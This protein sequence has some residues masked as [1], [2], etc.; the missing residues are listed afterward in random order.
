[1]SAGAGSLGIAR[2]TGSGAGGAASAASV[3]PLSSARASPVP[4][5][6]GHQP[7]PPTSGPRAPEAAS[8]PSCPSAQVVLNGT[9]SDTLLAAG[10]TGSW[11]AS[12]P[13]GQ[14]GMWLTGFQV[15]ASAAFDNGALTAGS[16]S[17]SVELELTAAP[18]AS[19]GGPGTSL[20]TPPAGEVVAS[21]PL[22][23][24]GGSDGS[25][26]SGAPS[27]LSVAVPAADPYLTIFLTASTP[28]LPDLVVSSAMAVD[29]VA[30]GAATN[31]VTGEGVQPGGES[32][33]S[34]GAP[35]PA[36][37]SSSDPSALTG[38]TVTGFEV[39]LASA[40]NGSA[41]APA[42]AYATATAYLLLT[43]TAGAPWNGP[44]AASASFPAGSLVL[45]VYQVAVP[46]TLGSGS[47]ALSVDCLDVV[48]PSATPYL[49]LYLVANTSTAA[50]LE[51]DLQ[52]TTYLT[53]SGI[54]GSGC[55]AGG[56][57]QAGGESDTVG[58]GSGGTGWWAAS[59][60]TDLSGDYLNG[61]QVGVTENF[62]GAP[63][64]APRFGNTL[65]WLFLSPV[66][67]TPWGS[68]GQ[69]LPSFPV[70][71]VVVGAWVL[72]V[73]SQGD[74]AEAGV[75]VSCLNVLVP[76]GSPYLSLLIH[77]RGAAG[78]TV[79]TQ[80]V[81]Y[82]T[83]TTHSTGCDVQRNATA[84]VSQSVA[85][86]VGAIP[87]WYAA[88]APGTFGGD[89]VAGASLGL[90]IAAD[91]GALSLPENS[92]ATA[93]LLATSSFFAGNNASGTAVAAL[94]P[95]TVLAAIPL[96]SGAG[97]GASETS[98]SLS[99]LDAVLSP[100]D[101]FLTVVL[102]VSTGPTAG[103]SVGVVSQVW[104]ESPSLTTSCPAP[105]TFS[106][107]SVQAGG[108]EDALPSAGTGW[109]VSSDP[110]SL[111]G[112][113][114]T[115]VQ[116]SGA[117]TFGTATSTPAFGEATFSLFFSPGPFTPWSSNGQALGAYPHEVSPFGSWT[118]RV[119]SANSSAGLSEAFSC[120]VVPV[121]AAAPYLSLL[122]ELSA[123][124]SSGL[125]GGWQVAVGSA[126]PQSLGS[127]VRAFP[128]QGDASVTSFFLTAAPT[129]GFPPYSAVW[130]L[131]NGATLP[132]RSINY[133]YTLPGIYTVQE[134]T[135]DSLGNSSLR[136]LTL[137]VS[138]V[139]AG[140]ATVTPTGPRDVGQTLSFSSEVQGG[141]PPIA[142]LWK[143]GDGSG[144]IFQNTTH[145]YRT[146]GNYS[147]SYFAND[148]AGQS[149]VSVLPVEI[150]PDPTASPTVL[151]AVAE[152]G[153]PV[154][155]TANGS[156]GVPPLSWSWRFGDGG[157]SNVADPV[158]TYASPG[159]FVAT[160][161]LN[162]SAGLSTNR[163]VLVTVDAPL[164][165]VLAFSS[166]LT[167]ASSAQGVLV[168]SSPSGGSG[169]YR[170]SWTLNGT[171]LTTTTPSFRFSPVGAGNFSFVSV[172]TD[173]AG[174]SA[175]DQ[176]TLTLRPP[177][178]VGL[179][180][181]PSSVVLGG[182]FRVTASV[183]APDGPVALVWSYLPSPC[184]AQN[185]SSFSC[186]PSSTGDYAIK[187]TVTDSQGYQTTATVG[188]NVAPAPAAAPSLL[189]STPFLEL[190]GGLV[191][192][193]VIVAIAVVRVRRR[194]QRATAVDDSA[195]ASV[196]APASDPASAPASP[197]ASPTESAQ[198]PVPQVAS[199][200]GKPRALPGPPPSTAPGASASSGA[201]TGAGGR[202]EAR[203]S[204]PRTGSGP[205]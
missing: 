50:S 60:S 7:L 79:H 26:R 8:G 205:G 195:S 89:R 192:V 176:G 88:S 167:R 155:F 166:N 194:G 30:P 102:E 104:A 203:P 197:P 92:S 53:A 189:S 140:S 83:V 51:I 29:L 84:E 14:A 93:W 168:S 52:S 107:A 42:A 119:G 149:F 5:G 109:W 169:T 28:T 41:L 103:L 62:A 44:G 121:P 16:A 175:S 115:S 196:S 112:Q 81:T 27:C 85:V 35:G 11:A 55:E 59:D 142:F 132:G 110:L 19:W 4:S 141:A 64:S 151:P 32:D 160:L 105:S 21:W 182:S 135:N 172:V 111:A 113:V 25:V 125:E 9:T 137:S 39:S 143:F 129:G 78:L 144:S 24:G 54:L 146:P 82:A 76:N 202:A 15:S 71:A 123:P 33:V 114:V 95:G 101:P 46:S 179:V 45:G 127:V 43:S 186:T 12:Y 163:S 187:V 77:S 75:F 180:V 157:S 57:P 36:A 185:I 10:G 174:F 170:F 73:G 116:L 6:S 178:R 198:P 200:P 173:S 37:W 131:G 97:Y 158:H 156:G 199:E 130:A 13:V 147:V 63:Y 134:W 145:A 61:F 191:V 20:L 65:V 136:T 31:C 152:V 2:S 47:V 48:V 99:C 161:F 87:S 204:L 181:D 122:V 69:S 67:Y 56:M 128:A 183:Y 58:A 18:Y 17:A 165:D 171:A 154:A 86:A 49:S 22:F 126:H 80:S 66:Q 91:P 138:P 188:V 193:A 184:S 117:L 120:L 159:A 164:T 72:G 70:G 34:S 177:L 139:P 148:S 3:T 153:Q 150:F 96:A 94:P 133:T 100:S 90:S 74:H 190:V 68:G 23:V 118:L 38:E 1:M 40:Y 124:V 98:V 162:D 108:Q 106:G 201:G